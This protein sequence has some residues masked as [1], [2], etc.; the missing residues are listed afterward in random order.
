M[1][2]HFLIFKVLTALLVYIFNLPSSLLREWPVPLSLE[3][4]WIL[5]SIVGL[6]VP[7]MMYILYGLAK[8]KLFS[9]KTQHN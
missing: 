8:Q 6:V 2:F 1:T 9:Y 7:Y 3:G 4:Y 5:Y